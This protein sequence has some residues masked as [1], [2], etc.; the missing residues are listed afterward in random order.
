MMKNLAF[1]KVCSLVNNLI[2]IMNDFHIYLD[3]LWTVKGAEK[4][5]RA[6]QPHT[7]EAKSLPV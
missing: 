2:E 7:E 5:L 3:R 4:S 1:N 6:K